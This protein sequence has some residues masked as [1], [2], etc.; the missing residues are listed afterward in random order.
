MP[1]KRLG[2]GQPAFHAS[3]QTLQVRS[4]SLR[5]RNRSLILH[6]K[7]KVHVIVAYLTDTAMGPG[8]S[9]FALTW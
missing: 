3:K 4:P 8:V 9:S 5:L 7:L 1:G 6:K 2:P